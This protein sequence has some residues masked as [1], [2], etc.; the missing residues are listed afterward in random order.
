MHQYIP[1][2]LLKDLADSLVPDG[3][4]SNQPTDLPYLFWFFT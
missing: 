1:Q 2:H 4:C 3:S